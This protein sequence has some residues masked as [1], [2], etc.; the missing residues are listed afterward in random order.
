MGK[1]VSPKRLVRQFF[2]SGFR[3]EQLNNCAS[4]FCC[5]TWEQSL[6]KSFLAWVLFYLAGYDLGDTPG[7]VCFKRSGTR[8]VRSNS[9]VCRSG[10]KKKPKAGKKSKVHLHDISITKNIDKWTPL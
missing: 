7:N 9:M 10:G 6:T 2:I 4:L 1:G 3:E 8:C 5:P